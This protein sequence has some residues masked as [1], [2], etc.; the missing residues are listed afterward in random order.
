MERNLDVLR[1]LGLP[2]EPL[3]GAA[4]PMVAAGGPAAE[5][6]AAGLDCGRE[7]F[8][9][10]SPGASARQAYKKPPAE[11]LV[12]AC[13][14]LRAREV[15]PLVVHGP[16]ELEQARAVARRAPAAVV[17]PPTDLPTLSGLAHRARLFVGGDSGPLHLACAA[18]CPVVGL[19][20]P[21]DPQVN[22]PWGVPFRAV[23]PPGRRYTG[24]KRIDRRSGGFAGITAN[25]VEAAIDELLGRP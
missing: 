16:G 3:P 4:L 10:I 24:I 13:E 9:L 5:R 17:A 22:Q 15:R 1:L 6:I 11:L 23:H 14:R 2:V 7:G 20:G 8:A 18:G 21:T 25:Q 19:Y 12:A